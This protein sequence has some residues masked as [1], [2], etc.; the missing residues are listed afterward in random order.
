[1][2]Q[3]PISA[4][5][6]TEARRIL[7]EYDR[8]DREIPS[9][10][11]ALFHPQN[12]FAHQE[13][14]RMLLHCLRRAG[15]VPL[16]NR[17]VLDLGC[18]HGDWLAVFE[19]LGAHRECLAGIELGESRADLAARRL[20]G[21]DIRAGDATHL[22]WPDHSF[23]VIFQRMMFTSIVDSA[24]RRA[25]ADEAMRVA[26]P[27][28]AIVWCDFFVNPRNPRVCPLG[29]AEVRALFPNWR[30]TFYRTT[31]APPLARRLVPVSWTL[32]RAIERLRI[33]NTFY[34]AL[35]QPPS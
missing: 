6:E 18:G 28:G 11:Y 29:R 30:A 10:F 1:V 13:H 3:S 34:F 35:L 24:A 32:A 14:E 21:A 20:P 9:D 25:S 26:R 7:A 33:L 17:R 31:L 22:P 8:R 12:L 5:P 15:L 4:E 2:N 23:D 19:G 16:G 27:E